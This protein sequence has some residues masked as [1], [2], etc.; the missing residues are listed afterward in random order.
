MC[1]Q[2][3]TYTVFSRNK[4]QMSSFNFNLK[5][6]DDSIPRSLNPT[7][8]GITLDPT[9]CFNKHISNTY[10]KA[11]DRL[12]IIKILSHKSW[13]LTPDTLF[14]I[15]KALV[16]SIF[17]YSSFCANLIS[18]KWM[19]KLQII[20]NSAI[21]FIFYI[22]YDTASVDLNEIANAYNL[23]EIKLRMYNLNKNH[24]LK[25][26]FYSN[27]LIVQLIDEYKR[28]FD[29]GR[30]ITRPTPPCANRTSI[31]TYFEASLDLSDH[32]P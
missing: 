17:N 6:F 5:L 4:K 11:L 18:P 32:T 15:Y 14:N 3:C 30:K 12:N 29:G 16:G 2:K 7:F 22:P 28:G 10:D 27:P 20:Q 31:E 9:L 23:H 19:H 13:K 21:R 24:I 25:N 1:A 8:L 26:I